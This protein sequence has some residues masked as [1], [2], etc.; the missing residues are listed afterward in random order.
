[1]LRKRPIPPISIGIAAD[2][3]PPAMRPATATAATAAAILA[4][5]LSLGACGGPVPPHASLPPDAVMGVGDPTRAAIISTA[6]AFNTPASVA[7][8]PVDAARA[9]AQVEHLATEIPYGPRWVEFSPLVGRELVAAR[10]ELRSALGI[11]PDAPPQAVVDALYA[12]SRALATGDGDAA[13]RVLPPPAFRDGRATLARLASL[14]SL[15]R[16]GTATALTEREMIRVDQTSRY[17][18]DGGD[19]GRGN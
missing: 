12:A 4:F 2:K 3:E 6:Y 13:A 9:A 16:T 7:R 17:S 11:A 8:R 15:P 18:T 1:M 10:G 19:G 5:S 14:P